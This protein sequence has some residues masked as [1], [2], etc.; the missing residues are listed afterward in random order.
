MDT[1]MN[2]TEMKHSFT[3]YDILMWHIAHIVNHSILC[4]NDQ[5]SDADGARYV[6]SSLE[7]LVKAKSSHG[8]IY[9]LLPKKN[10]LMSFL[11]LMSKFEL[12]HHNIQ[13]CAQP[14]EWI[15]LHQNGKFCMMAKTDK[16]NKSD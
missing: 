11:F 5:N 7:L 4:G 10:L 2:A 8:S 1:T 9:H 15:T 16:I 12:H 14:L 13:L 6:N 3:K